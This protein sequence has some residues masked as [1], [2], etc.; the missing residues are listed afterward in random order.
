MPKL[1]HERTQPLKSAAH[2]ETHVSDL[3]LSLPSMK[4]CS[5][6]SP[7]EANPSQKRL[8]SPEERIVCFLAFSLGSRTPYQRR[9]LTRPLYS[10]LCVL[11]QSSH[12]LSRAASSR[13]LRAEAAS[14]NTHTH[15][16]ILQQQQHTHNV[17]RH[18]WA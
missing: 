6:F 14:S 12:W 18:I 10:L 15:C 16:N 5:M 7:V 1:H 2:K 9:T 4:F 17:L 3:S 8:S 13:W 11:L